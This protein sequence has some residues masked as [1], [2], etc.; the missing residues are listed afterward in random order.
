MAKRL[1]MRP[2]VSAQRAAHFLMK[3]MFCMFG[4][5]IGL[6]PSKVFG[7]LLE[8]AKA[9]PA[10][11][12]RRLEN[13]FRAMA[14]GGDF[15]AEMIPHFNGGLFA[16]HDVVPLTEPE[17]NILLSVNGADWSN[18]EPSIF[19]TLFERHFD[20]EKEFLIGAHY[21]SRDDIVTLVEP[22]VMAPLRREWAEA[23]RRCD[24]ELWP[25]VQAA[26]RNGGQGRVGRAKRGPTNASRPSPARKAFDRALQDFAERL[27]HVTVLDPACGS[28]NFLYVAINLLLDLEKE[29]I[30][31]AAGHGLALF[32]HVRPTQLLGLEINRFAQELAQVVI[33]IGYLQWMH[34][35]G[36][37]PP[38]DP[39]LEP[40]ESIRCQDAILDLS[41]PKHPKEPEWPAAEFV[42]GNPPFLGSKLLRRASATST[43][44]PFIGFGRIV[45]HA[46]ATYAA[47]GSRKHGLRSRAGEQSAPG[48]WRLRASAGALTVG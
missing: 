6:L 36:F 28:G 26:A 8:T 34:H 24:E 7:R 39:V 32:P 33:W 17:I 18:V 20:P 38:S 35:N 11:L 40:I 45:F 15:G 44:T 16:D 41:N 25:K 10:M 48:C 43:L 13:L 22:V 3:L 14:D 37:K 1:R 46:K 31:Y 9:N 4:Q 23:R 19:G 21:T 30:A 27:H 42:V 5:R 47:T 12:S 2:G 29:V